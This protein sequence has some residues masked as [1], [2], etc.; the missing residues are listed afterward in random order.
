MVEESGIAAPAGACRTGSYYSQAMAA[1]P[2][3][4]ARPRPRLGS[5][6]RPVSV[7]LYRGTWLLVGIPLLVSAFS[8]HKAQP[9]PAPEPALPA[10]VDRADAVSLATDLSRSYPDR[11]APAAV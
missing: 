4:P 2:P 5:L 7:R 6:Q 9:L 1:F 3:R 8:V 10:A 11:D